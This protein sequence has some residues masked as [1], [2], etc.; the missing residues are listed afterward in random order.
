V[1]L[2]L[3]DWTSL[4]RLHMAQMINSVTAYHLKEGKS[5][6]FTTRWHSQHWLSCHQLL[7]PEPGMCVFVNSDIFFNDTKACQHTNTISVEDRSKTVLKTLRGICFPA[8][9]KVIKWKNN[10]ET[11]LPWIGKS[12]MKQLQG[13]F[14]SRWQAV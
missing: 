13:S 14:V 4:F 6:N 8:F 5:L 7:L 1:H 12:S 2:I 10:A 3:E 9:A 11:V